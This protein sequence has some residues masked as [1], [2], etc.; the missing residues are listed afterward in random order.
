[1]TKQLDIF[2]ER[3][4]RDEMQEQFDEFDKAHPQVYRLF[5]RFTLE[6]I[7]RGFKHH[8]AHIVMSRVRWESPMGADGKADFKVNNNHAAFYSRKFMAEHPEY[9]GFFRTR[10]QVSKKHEAT[11]REPLGPGDYPTYPKPPRQIAP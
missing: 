4:R 8:S 6:L 2:S 7:G 1:M 11:G 3:T 9:A 10:E 5:K